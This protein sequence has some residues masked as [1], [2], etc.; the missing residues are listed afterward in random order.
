MTQK[1]TN[2][3]LCRLTIFFMSK[4]DLSKMV[5]DNHL[6]TLS[7]Y[8]EW[9]DTIEFFQLLLYLSDNEDCHDYSEYE[10]NLMECFR[11]KGIP[12][13]L[14][15]KEMQRKSRMLFLKGYTVK[16]SFGILSEE[17]YKEIEPLIL[18]RFNRKG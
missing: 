8:E 7:M 6:G 5:L 18:G 1:I 9:N 14:I 10:D 16:E 11:L 17:I 3:E 15:D 4:S 12:T 13:I 2:I